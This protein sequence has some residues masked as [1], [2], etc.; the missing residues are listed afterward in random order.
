MTRSFM[1][2]AVSVFLITPCFAQAPAMSHDAQKFP[3]GVDE[4]TRI[5]KRVLEREGYQVGSGGNNW[6]SGSREI[7]R[8]L[9]LCDGA[10]DGTWASV[11]VSS[12]AQEYTVPGSELRLIM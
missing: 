2:T 7:H 11:I 3:V 8:A 12:S 6:V 4:C 10:Q 9:I 5:G 1:L